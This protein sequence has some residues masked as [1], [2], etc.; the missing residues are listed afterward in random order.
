MIYLY[1]LGNNHPKYFDTKHNLGWMVAEELAKETNSWKDIKSMKV[2]KTAKFEAWLSLGYMNHSGQ[3]FLE[4]I[5]YKKID[6]ADEDLLI[7]A[8]DDSDQLSGRLKL[9]Q[10]GRSGGHKGITDI[11]K[12]LPNT[13]L[14]LDQIWRLK[15]GI[16]PEGNKLRS[17]TFVLNRASQDELEL[18]K[19][20][21]KTLL[22]NWHLVQNRELNKLQT[23]LHSRQ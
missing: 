21:A 18:V 19:T 15:L 6:F 5:S 22:Q 9:V 16:R 11:Y 17:E 12:Y 1:G 8:H 20:T 2:A 13:N 10:G 7:I 23:I 14:K 3:S 4:Y